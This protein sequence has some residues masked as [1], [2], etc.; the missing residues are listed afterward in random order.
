MENTKEI[1]FVNYVLD[2]VHGFIGL[3]DIE[4]KIE[5]LPI[6]KRLQDISQLGLVKRIFPGALHNRYIHSL[7]VMHVI[8]Q[9]ALHL[10]RFS[11]AERQLLRIAGM[12]HDLGH[13]PL[14]HDLE[15]V[16]DRKEDLL[17]ADFPPVKEI[18][19]DDLQNDINKIIGTSNSE[20]TSE[21]FWIPQ[22]EL[23]VKG[24]FH[25]ETVTTRVI[26][27]SKSIYN[28][29]VDGIK[30]GYFNDKKT[31]WDS[32]SDED[33]K[34]F[35]KK[36]INDICALIQGNSDYVYEEGAFPEHF[37][38][39]LQML[40]SEL[41][42][43]RIDYLLRDA[44]FSGASYGSFDLG[45]L[46]QNLDMKEYTIGKKSVWIVGVREKGI[47]CADQYMV[48]RY[49]AYTQVIFNKYTSIIAKMLREIVRWMMNNMSDN[50]FYSPDNMDRIIKQHE[51]N[52]HYL[53][54]TDSYFFNKLNA[55]E[56][57][58][59]GCPDDIYYFIEQ[60]RQFRALDVEMEDVFSGNEDIQKKHIKE[61]EFYK[62]INKLF[63]NENMMNEEKGLYLLCKKKLT[64]HMPFNIFK[65]NFDKYSE[66]HERCLNYEMYKI[67]RLMDGLAVIFE[68][69]EPILL[70]DSPRSMLSQFYDMQQIMV[71]KY[72][73]KSC[74]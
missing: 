29:I 10:K 11:N 7:G 57:I 9:M 28:I 32:S 64:N 45:I 55:V 48:N 22:R 63:N 24:R 39:M 60:L 44:T 56:K 18:F 62:N 33:V 51:E 4:D 6:F 69:K 47:G 72:V 67:D 50:P 16:Y 58:K 53:A 5:R 40:H 42:A 1:V 15:Q 3:T 36:I 14:S 54:F 70:I 31:N 71:R 20:N 37:T 59:H 49:L 12:L 19:Y 23:V 27:A 26:N 13:Y 66:K 46:L 52:Q 35:A 34:I 21:D 43:D 61:S 8:D 65:K 25:H 30:Q 68:D 41:D 17:E 74:Y 38:A 2:N 73:F